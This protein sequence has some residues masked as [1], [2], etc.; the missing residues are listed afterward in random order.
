MA[1][2]QLHVWSH[3]SHL[4]SSNISADFLAGIS[5][6]TAGKTFSVYSVVSKTSFSDES[7]ISSLLGVALSALAKASSRLRTCRRS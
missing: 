3:W 4:K 6:L 1:S 7:D 5:A 2:L